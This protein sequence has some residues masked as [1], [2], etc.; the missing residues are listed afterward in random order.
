MTAR[1]AGAIAARILAVVSLIN[2]I[3]TL[4]STIQLIPLQ[5]QVSMPY[6]LTSATLGLVG[7]FAAW[8]LWATSPKFYI[9]AGEATA[10]SDL[11]PHS[12]FR[13]ALAVLGAYFVISSIPNLAINVALSGARDDVRETLGARSGVLSSLITLML[14]AG[15]LGFNMPRKQH[16]SLDE[17]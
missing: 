2:G 6:L 5:D 15:L 8:I 4:I 9:P 10:S 11:D 1:D 12:L 13:I 17:P 16:V 14:G 3:R 7:I